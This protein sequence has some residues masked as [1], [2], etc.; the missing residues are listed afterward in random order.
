M[1]I[2]RFDVIRIIF[3]ACY[4][5]SAGVLIYEACQNGTDSSNKSSFVGGT[6]AN[7]I[8]GIGGDQTVDVAPTSLIINN[9]I[10]EAHVGDEITLTTTTL[11]EDATN[12]SV[13]FTSSDPN[14]ASVTSGGYVK[15][16]KQGNATITAENINFVDVKDSM[17]VAVSNIEVESIKSS[18]NAPFDG[19]IYTLTVGKTYDIT[20]VIEPSN[21]TVQTVKYEISDNEYVG[22]DNQ[23]KIAA[24]SASYDNVVEIKANCGLKQSTLKVVTKPYEVEQI[25]LKTIAPVESSKDIYVTELY[26]PSYAF[27]PIES[28]EKEYSLSSNNSNVASIVE[29]KTV[30]GMKEGKAIITATSTKNPNVKC[31]IELAVKTQPSVTNFAIEQSLTMK[32]GAE[33]SIGVSNIQPTYADDTAIT[34]TSENDDIATISSEGKIKAIKTGTTN[35]N[36]TIGS[37]TK[38]I[39]LTVDAKPTDEKTTDFD[40]E[41][42]KEPA[43][44]ANKPVKVSSFIKVTNFKSDG[45]TYI[46]NDSNMTYS[47]ANSSFG[48]IEGDTL[49][50][51]YVGEFTLYITHDT[52]GITKEITFTSI[53]DFLIDNQE[54][55]EQRDIH[56]GEL[57]EF[58]ICKSKDELTR[59]LKKNQWWDISHVDDSVITVKDN[60]NSHDVTG[61]GEGKA[62]ITITPYLDETPINDLS[63]KITVDVTHIRSKN[64]NASLTRT[65]LNGNRQELKQNQINKCY[66][67]D[68]FELTAEIDDDATSSNICFTSSD[69]SIL[70][71]T[72]TGTLTPKSIGKVTITAIES[73]SGIEQSFD[74][75]I[76]NRILLSQDMPFTVNGATINE[77]DG[78]YEIMNGTIG[79]II[80]NYTDDTTYKSVQWKSDNEKI[81]T[82]GGD[83]T[84]SPLKAGKATISATIDD[85]YSS[86]KSELTIKLNITKQPVIKDLQE[87]FGFIRKAVGH[88]G[89]FLVFGVFSALTFM[90]W[91]RG[92]KWYWSTP[93]TFVQGFGL[94]ALTECIQLGVP[95]RSGAFTDVLI[96]S[97]GCF[98]GIIVTGGLIIWLTIWHWKKTKT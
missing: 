35:I 93:L 81:V 16:L 59:D 37:I 26:T 85:G 56:Y 82:I 92:K 52:S 43:I 71:V 91:F 55:P 78:Y 22:L 80:L 32:E 9:K 54:V 94:A 50:S 46:P 96:D 90:M 3:T 84:I 76:E 20:N 57:F 77:S 36:V 67:N 34:F 65:S 5:F 17:T 61:V 89:A 18:I 45:G 64:F 40:F 19:D 83:G 38:S 63:K 86:E 10:S 44:Y 42:L 75:N 60:G 24:L 23:G 51:R 69:S 11:P 2:K 98:I 47:L 39:Q 48:S 58:T 29:G 25:P 68:D 62:K 88:F 28:T 74:L 95:G 6:I 97:S 41:L 7:L 4:L 14:I 30:R 15:F 49:T 72:N 27:Y 79:S 1:K 21:A 73:V 12:K 70:E 8:N 31:S 87:F 66:I 33:R 13:N 53:D